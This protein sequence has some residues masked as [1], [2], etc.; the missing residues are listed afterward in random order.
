VASKEFPLSFD[1]THHTDNET[2]LKGLKRW[3]PDGNIKTI[4]IGCNRPHTLNIFQIEKA[5]EKEKSLKCDTCG[6][7]LINIT[8]RPPKREEHVPVPH[9]CTHLKFHPTTFE[10][11]PKE[12]V[13]ARKKAREKLKRRSTHPCP[14][15]RKIEDG[16][17][18]SKEKH[19]AQKKQEAKL[20]AIQDQQEVSVQ[21]C[22]ECGKPLSKHRKK[23]DA[24]SGKWIT[25][26]PV[27]SR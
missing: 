7:I 4:C 23:L 12:K 10:G 2:T 15:C 21:L 8:G 9:K 24:G 20:S 6:H 27:K 5:L 1:L 19:E 17:L 3:F 18:P 14:F 13:E 25:V 11:E 26:H 16:E 22:G